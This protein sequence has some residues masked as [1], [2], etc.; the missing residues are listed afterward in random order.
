MHKKKLINPIFFHEKKEVFSLQAFVF[1]DD[2]FY[3]D[4]VRFRCLVDLER[5]RRLCLFIFRIRFFFKFP[6]VKAF[7]EDCFWLKK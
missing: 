7:L 3:K 4:H 2:K 6:I 5:F 1:T